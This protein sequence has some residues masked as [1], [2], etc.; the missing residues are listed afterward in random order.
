MPIIGFHHAQ[1][2]IPKGAEAQARAFY[3]TLLGLTETEK[4][5][6]LKERGGFWAAVG[7]QQ[8]HISINRC[9]PER[10]QSPSGL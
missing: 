4:P 8:L 3:C 5:D 7:N 1:I 2:T 10:D 9:R 6:S